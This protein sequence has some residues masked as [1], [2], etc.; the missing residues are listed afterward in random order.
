MSGARSTDPVTSHEAAA[1]SGPSRESQ[2][3][4]LLR[5]YAG[6]GPAG[7]TADEAGEI[8]GLVDVPNCNYWHRC[9]DLREQGLIE[10]DGDRKRYSSRSE[11]RQGVSIITAAG[12]RYLGMPLL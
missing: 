7:L 2:R 6:A 8:T 5:A 4:K 12:Y 9:S 1:A 3:R 10:W 11:R